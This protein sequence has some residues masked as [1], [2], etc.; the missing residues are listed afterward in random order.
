M[1][2]LRADRC[3][4]TYIVTLTMTLLAVGA[5]NL[6]RAELREV[7]TADEVLR[8]A[9]LI[10]HVHVT[11][12]LEFGQRKV[13]LVEVLH[14]A[15]GP[16]AGQLVMLS[17]DDAGFVRGETFKPG[18]QYLLLAER[19]DEGL[20]APLHGGSQDG[21]LRDGPDAWQVDSDGT[22]ARDERLRSILP[23]EV[24]L[25]IDHVVAHLGDVCARQQIDLQVTINADDVRHWERGRAL[26]AEIS[27]T[28]SG[29]E[30][31]KFQNY[32]EFKCQHNTFIDRERLEKLREMSA[33]PVVKLYARRVR[34]RHE[35]QALEEMVR[36][37]SDVISLPPGKQAV[38]AYDLGEEWEFNGGGSFLVW[39]ELGAAQSP[40]VLLD[41]PER[42]E[43]EELLEK[44]EMLAESGPFRFIEN[45]AKRHTMPPV[46]PVVEGAAIEAALQYWLG[47]CR[48]SNGEEDTATAEVVVLRTSNIASDYS[49]H[50]PNAH[51]VHSNACWRNDGKPTELVTSQGPA[52]FRWRTL[53]IDAVEVRGCE[54]TVRIIQNDRHNLGTSGATIKLRR[55]EGKW[56]VAGPVQIWQS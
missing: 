2:W 30:A 3:A 53:R 37:L 19:N 49:P 5:A 39:A 45:R 18:Q 21:G 23:P 40:A 22:L 1:M 17:L 26:R 11:G 38:G 42:H 55:K 52:I 10:A 28:N 13:Q 9:A 31:F 6:S 48:M 35:L 51:F 43:A 32:I 46:G 41:L 12:T 44:A 33:T 15:R 4:Y 8:S 56:H 36:R 20:Y 25:K 47:E 29:E 24:P 50:V 16:S 54:A 34:V 7:L 14:A 27:I